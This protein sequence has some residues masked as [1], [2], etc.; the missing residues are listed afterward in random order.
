[1]IWPHHQQ[2]IFRR[3]HAVAGK[4]IQNGVLAEKG[5]GKVHE[6]GD[7]AVVRI[8]PERSELKLL[9]VLDFLAFCALVSL[10]W[11]KRVVLE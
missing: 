4:D 2:H 6:I 5:L 1:M 3:E 9:L 10:I 11:L 8:R 7:N